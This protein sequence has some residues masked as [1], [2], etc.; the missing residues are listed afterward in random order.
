VRRFVRRVGLTDWSCWRRSWARSLR[1]VL[2]WVL[3]GV[4]HVLGP[5]YVNMCSRKSEFENY[6]VNQ[7]DQSPHLSQLPRTRLSHS[8]QPH[9]VLT[10]VEIF[11]Q[12]LAQLLWSGKRATLLYPS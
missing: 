7:L 6:L 9:C 12:T 4:S 2:S 8:S 3:S 10:S 11:N 5:K 1:V